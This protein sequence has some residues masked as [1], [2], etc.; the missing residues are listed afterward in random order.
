MP[1]RHKNKNNLTAQQ[2]IRRLIGK[3]LV[4]LGPTASGAAAEAKIIVPHNQDKVDRITQETVGQVPTEVQNAINAPVSQDRTISEQGAI[5][6][7]ERFSDIELNSISFKASQG[8]LSPDKENI[9][10]DYNTRLEYDLEDT[11]KK[12]EPYTVMLGKI[13]FSST[14]ALKVQKLVAVGPDGKELYRDSN[15]L[16]TSMVMTNPKISPESDGIAFSAFDE[17]TGLTTKVT[18]SWPSMIEAMIGSESEIG[19]ADASSTITINGKRIDIS[20]SMKSWLRNY[21]NS[22]R[23]LSLNDIAPPLPDISGQAEKLKNAL[24]E[25]SEEAQKAVIEAIEPFLFKVSGQIFQPGHI[26]SDG[27]EYVEHQVIGT[28]K[29]YSDLRNNDKGGG[30]GGGVI[31]APA[32]KLVQLNGASKGDVF[33]H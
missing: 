31:V 1:E 27:L 21:K 28:Y 25:S 9:Q 13:E 17:A 14:D 3:L 30:G 10:P 7:R 20:N 29:E 24:N 6:L 2:K 12:C 5:A 15:E 8:V 11:L 16:L 19:G 4:I 22:E 18:I 33:E 23:H 32:A 26:D